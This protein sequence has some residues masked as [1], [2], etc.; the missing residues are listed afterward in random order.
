MINLYFYKNHVMEKNCFKC[1]KVLP[2]TEFYKHSQ[3]SDG[4]L[5]KCKECAK[6][7]VKG[8]YLSNK[9]DDGYLEK[10]RKRGRI[11]Y[12]KLYSNKINKAN[13]ERSKK[14]NDRYPEKYQVRSLSA[15]LKNPDKTLEKHHWSYNVEHAKNV[16]WLTKK[17]HKK[18]HRFIIY[19]QE[20]KMYRRFDN[21]ILLDTL[22]IHNEFIVDCILNQED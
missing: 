11:K 12:R 16:I 15:S 3:M 9:K 8:N 14:Y 17:H 19:D 4:H 18:A 10:E 1:R 22:E 20:R 7:D 2:L 13:P 21:N 5:N 6:N